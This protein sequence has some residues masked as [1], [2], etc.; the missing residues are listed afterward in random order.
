MFFS[1]DDSDI[2]ADAWEATPDF[3][4]LVPP[5][6]DSGRNRGARAAAAEQG[7]SGYT[8][9]RQRSHLSPFQQSVCQARPEVLLNPKN[10]AELLCQPS[11]S[12]QC[13]TTTSIA[14]GGSRSAMRLQASAQDHRSAMSLAAA[15]AGLET[16]NGLCTQT[17]AAKATEISSTDDFFASIEREAAERNF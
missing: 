15:A 6:E 13:R 1:G 12:H 8:S 11:G 16:T 5:R 14:T 7:N 10:S 9:A 2:P 4:T 3:D 17:S